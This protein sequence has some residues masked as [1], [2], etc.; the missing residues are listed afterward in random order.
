MA[1]IMAKS[2]AAKRQQSNERGAII[3]I[4]VIVAVVFIIL[5]LVMVSQ[6]QQTTV[7]VKAGKYKDIPQTTTS[8]GAP[9]LG[10]PDAKVTIMEFADFSCPHC[11]EYQPTIEQVIEQLVKPGLVRVVYRPETFVG[12]Q[13]SQTAAEA[14]LCAG[15]QNGF[16]DMHDAIYAMQSTKGYRSFTV[17]EM[18]NLANSLNL[19]GGAV[20]QCMANGEMQKA[21]QASYDI[22][23]KYGVQGT[24]A[25]MYS[26]DGAN[27]KWFNDQ[28]GQPER[29]GVDLSL[30]F[31][32]VQINSR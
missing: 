5:A 10:S 2:K 29:G 4:I 27:F 32:V 17:E 24:P 6:A 15:K 13:F 12:G 20:T 22:G 26:T 3:G 1:K 31:A 18:R 28:S 30:I 19:D 8:D 11:L 25:V 21:L 14:A 23:Q 9:V 16:W 7:N